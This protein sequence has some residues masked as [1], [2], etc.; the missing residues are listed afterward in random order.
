MRTFSNKTNRR[1]GVCLFSCLISAGTMYGAGKSSDRLVAPSQSV[2]GGTPFGFVTDQDASEPGIYRRSGNS[3]TRIFSGNLLQ[4]TDLGPVISELPVSRATSSYLSMSVLDGKLILFSK[5]SQEKKKES[6]VT[7]GSPQTPIYDQIFRKS[8]KNIDKLADADAIQIYAPTELTSKG[9]QVVLVSIPR[10]SILGDGITFAMLIEVTNDNNQDFKLSSRPTVVSYNYMQAASLPKLI[11]NDFSIYHHAALEFFAAPHEYSDIPEYAKWQSKMEEYS[12]DF[13]QAL[14]KSQAKNTIPRF[15]ITKEEIILPNVPMLSGKEK[16]IQILHPLNPPKYIWRG[17]QESFG[18]LNLN[19]DGN[20]IHYKMDD[21]AHLTFLNDNLQFTR[22]ANNNA[23]QTV[24]LG[25]LA[26]LPGDDISASMHYSTYTPK[27]GSP[28]SSLLISVKRNFDDTATK[29]IGKYATEKEGTYRVIL[30]SESSPYVQIKST[31][32]ISDQFYDSDDLPRRI[33]NISRIIKNHQQV[34]IPAVDVETPPTDS[35]VEYTQKLQNHIPYISLF[36]NDV[37]N[38][39]L[40]EK[41]MHEY[42][43]LKN[44]L[45]YKVYSD[46]TLPADYKQTGFYYENPKSNEMIHLPTQLLDKDGNYGLL[47]TNKLKLG[48]DQESFVINVFAGDSAFKKGVNGFSLRLFM[49]EPDKTRSIASTEI[50]LDSFESFEDV[51]VTTDFIG[52]VPYVYVFTSFKSGEKGKLRTIK[53]YSYKYDKETASNPNELIQ[54]HTHTISKDS[55]ITLADIPNRIILDNNGVSYWVSNPDVGFNDRDLSVWSLKNP[56]RKEEWPNRGKLEKFKSKKGMRTLGERDSFNFKYNAWKLTPGSI[57]NT[58]KENPK[59]FQEEVFAEFIDTFENQAKPGTQAKHVVYIVPEGMEDQLTAL[60]YR[61]WKEDSGDHWK[62]SNSN[63]ALFHIQNATSQDLFFDSLKDIRD[64]VRDGTKTVFVEKLKTIA[65]LHPTYKSADSTDFLIEDVS[66]DEEL[67]TEDDSMQVVRSRPSALYL[68]STEGQSIQPIELKK[69]KHSHDISMVLIGTESQWRNTIEQAGWE[70]K[71]GL[72]EQWEVRSLETPDEGALVKLVESLLNRLSKKG[73]KYRFEVNSRSRRNQAVS[74]AEVRDR[75]LR[76]AVNK[77]IALADRNETNRYTAFTR[78]YRH[79][80]IM[81]TDDL[82]TRKSG[83][84]SDSWIDLQF[85]RLFKMPLSL[86]LLPAND[87]HVLASRRD[88]KMK[89]GD[90]GYEASF[91]RIQ[92]ILDMVLAKTSGD[93]TL[94]VP[95]SM[96]LVGP[97]GTGKTRLFTAFTQAFGIKPYVWGGTEQQNR[98]AQSM[99]ISV[100]MLKGKDSQGSDLVKGGTQNVDDAIKKFWEFIATPRGRMG[101]ILFD[102]IHDGSPEVRSKIYTVIKTL[103]DS[104]EGT[105]T[106]TDKDKVEIEIPASNLTIFMSMNLEVKNALIKEYAENPYNP[107]LSDLIKANLHLDGQSFGEHMLTRI[108]YIEEVGE[109]SIDAKGMSLVN[110]LNEAA[111]KSLQATAST[112]KY[113][114]FSSDF[115]DRIVKS[116]PAMNGR[117][118]NAAATREISSLTPAGALNVIIPKD[119]SDDDTPIVTEK[120]KG[121][122]GDISKEANLINGWVE[123]ELDII[124]VNSN[125]MEGKL[126]FMK[127]IANSFRSQAYSGLLK[128]VEKDKR[129]S[130][131]EFQRD[132]LLNPMYRAFWAHWVDRD[133][134]PF[135]NL[136]FPRQSIK[137]LDLASQEK[138]K[139]FKERN[140][141]E[142]D[143]FPVDLSLDIP[144]KENPFSSDLLTRRSH[145]RTRRILIHEKA[146]K[147]QTIL[148][149]IFV[150]NYRVEN[151]VHDKSL[152]GP[153][154]LA[155]EQKYYDWLT[156]IKDEPVDSKELYAELATEIL[157]FIEQFDS[158]DLKEGKDLDKPI[159]E[160]EYK[161]TSMDDK[162]RFLAMTIDLALMNMPFWKVSRMLVE[163]LELAVDDPATIE[164]AGVQRYL[165]GK[166]SPFKPGVS[167]QIF[168]LVKASEVFENWNEDTKS[169]YRQ[170]FSESC[171]GMLTKKEVVIDTD[172]ILELN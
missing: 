141:M 103:L 51:L 104:N 120:S 169:T 102:D 150:A 85:T 111:T 158:S 48:K 11:L 68:L 41:A 72:S 86:D 21:V 162:M 5:N 16:L 31:S 44:W 6:F 4:H 53:M 157:D 95:S 139:R 99:I 143:F 47:S 36:E 60:T 63:L 56:I 113:T 119:V 77:L 90:V 114:M 163:A 14:E 54:I 39:Y 136:K 137:Q 45:Q 66:I 96:L 26:I 52:G 38:Q 75:V 116:F 165:L 19:K 134:I 67:D 126:W 64:Q 109:F 91:K 13:F 110:R 160:R 93:S 32:K 73:L 37:K 142:E 57:E 55:A 118:F 170:S 3:W 151:I 132:N 9:K 146:K 131:S 28:S 80:S 83:V 168:H 89:F 145:Q 76:Y 122:T 74:E 71:F 105:I 101:Y 88:A 46:E 130:Y 148:S 154:D 81:L 97:P 128:A 17:N 167:D 166:D 144:L 164:L 155:K 20:I 161:V 129:F 65:N 138:V 62:R 12:E 153:L 2:H 8:Y 40:F 59:K 23:V 159:E 43:Y 30:N 24:E 98:D 92:K 112:F 108:A 35:G 124:E 33:R 140:G 147:F 79:I 84:I 172:D 1:L 49:A 70:E 34:T 106:V 42:S 69:K 27:D 22:F 156:D 117:T 149:K 133:E 18:I 58:L 100:K 135:S 107:K 78:F 29:R 115:V 10:E 125:S 127:N 121:K 171:E 123:K 25:N 50:K 87:P 152:E 94:A 61:R 82:E 15:D 7:L